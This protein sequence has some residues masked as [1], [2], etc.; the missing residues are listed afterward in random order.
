MDQAEGQIESFR[1]ECLASGRCA[2]EPKAW[3]ALFKTITKGFSRD[4]WP[5]LPLILGA[6]GASPQS[7]LDRLIEHLEWAG[8]RGRTAEAFEF[9]AALTDQDWQTAKEES[10]HSTSYWVLDE[11]DE[12]E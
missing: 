8:S 7:K 12:A 1:S 9:L 11:E 6:S 3:D 4:E 10:W 5:P 2:P